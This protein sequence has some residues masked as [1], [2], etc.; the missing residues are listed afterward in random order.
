VV[1]GPWPLSQIML[2][3]GMSCRSGLSRCPMHVG[4]CQVRECEESNGVCRGQGGH[5]AAREQPQVLVDELRAFVFE[6]LSAS[7]RPRY[8]GSQPQSK[9]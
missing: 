2:L 8:G 5:F 1:R 3:A 6:D 9:L 7:E 4:S